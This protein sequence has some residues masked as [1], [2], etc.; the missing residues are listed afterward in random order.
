M[1]VNSSSQLLLTQEVNVTVF[2]TLLTKLVHNKRCNVIAA[3]TTTDTLALAL[4]VTVAL[5]LALA[6]APAHPGAITATLG[7]VTDPID[8]VPALAPGLFPGPVLGPRPINGRPHL[9]LLLSVFLTRL[10]PST[11]RSPT[12]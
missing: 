12:I 6:L 4:V 2:P 11:S 8:L 5:A 10:L 9:R 1:L 7:P 3:D